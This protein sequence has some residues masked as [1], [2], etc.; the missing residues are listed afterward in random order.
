MKK[1]ISYFGVRRPKW[2]LEDMKEIKERGFTHVLHTWSEED[3]LYYRD[4]MQEI[5]DGSDEL[6]LKV[7]V[8][9]W[10][11]G[12]VFGGEAFSELVGRN[13]SL[14]QKTVDGKSK[15][16]AC[17]NQ[18]E[19]RDYMDQWIQAVC[20]TK[21]ETIFWDEPHFYFEKGNLNNWA[22]CC[23]QCQKIFFDKYGFKMPD[24]LTPEVQSFR[25]DSLID[26]LN[27]MTE[28]V[29][30]LGTRNSVCLLPPWFPAGIENWDRIAELPFVDEISSDPYWEKTTSSEIIKEN[31]REVSK[32]VLSVAHKY[33]KEAQIWIKNYHIVK[34][35]ESDVRLATEEAYD[36]G[37]RNIFAWSY[38]GSEYL[39]WLRSDNPELV[40]ET[41]ISALNKLK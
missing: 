27:V 9:P 21:V 12:R 36:A 7:Y 26:F 2:A 25:E 5:I 16:A 10:G 1:G 15:V 11:V 41:Q 20:S 14:A 18:Q 35:K 34:D 24:S 6:G 33:G 30:C 39:S 37:I 32:Q 23:D 28:K 22:C 3:L 31:Y 17:P 40:Y 38:L 19:F 4:S 8:N 13:F 29:H